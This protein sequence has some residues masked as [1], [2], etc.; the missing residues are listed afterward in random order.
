MKQKKGLIQIDFVVA[1][2]LFLIIFAFVVVFVTDY[3]SAI[4][5]DAM[6]ADIRSEALMLLGMAE[7]PPYP[8]AWPEKA[9]SSDIVLLMYLNNETQDHSQYGNNGTQNGGVNCS[10]GV[11][12]K[13]RGACEFDGV[14]DYVGVGN[15]ND[16]MSQF[17][18]EAWVNPAGFSTA[19]DIAISKHYG[20]IDREWYVLVLQSFICF[21]SY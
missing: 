20:G 8:L 7:Q 21:V 15:K 1:A 5:N 17:T 10:R 13:F 2:G 9:A 11:I 4:R 12:G 3:Y 19:M 14:N 6:I 16:G 18:L